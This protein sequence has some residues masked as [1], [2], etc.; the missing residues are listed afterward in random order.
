ML[1]PG[2]GDGF[3]FG[4]GRIAAELLEMGLDGLHFDQREI[5]L[6]PAA[7]DPQGLVVHRADRHGGQAEV[8]GSAQFQV[9]EAQGADDHLLDGVV[10]Q[11][12]CAERADAVGVEALDPVL[13]Q[14]ADHLGLQPEIFDRRHHALGHGVHDARLGKN[15]D[16]Q[17]EGKKGR[18]GRKGR[19]ETRMPRRLASPFLPCSLSP[20]PRVLFPRDPFSASSPTSATIT[21]STTVSVSSSKATRSAWQRSQSAWIR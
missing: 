2:L 17:G 16:E 6:P 9:T 11:D 8:V 18:R 21:L 20:L 13:L 7:Q 4:V 3:Q 15:V 1:A 5:K 14:R 10:G 12:L 19:R